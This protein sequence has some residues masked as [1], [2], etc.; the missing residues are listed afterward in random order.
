MQ[1][2]PWQRSRAGR[3]WLRVMFPA[4]LIFSVVFIGLL[5]RW[6]DTDK[7][8]NVCFA[9]VGTIFVLVIDVLNYRRYRLILKADA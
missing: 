7:V 1:I 3:L 5:W 4:S 6:S 8:S 9:V 2:G